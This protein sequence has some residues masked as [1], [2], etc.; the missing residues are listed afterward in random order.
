LIG[1]QKAGSL[2]LRPLVHA[3]FQ[4]ED[5]A[6]VVDEQKAEQQEMGQKLQFWSSRRKWAHFALWGSGRTTFLQVLPEMEWI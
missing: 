4:W 5:A 6:A 2:F 1:Q 3:E